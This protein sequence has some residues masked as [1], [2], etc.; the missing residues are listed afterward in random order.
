MIKSMIGKFTLLD[1]GRLAIRL[2]DISR[3]FEHDQNCSIILKTGGY[4][5]V[6]EDY[7]TVVE[8][9]SSYFDENEDEEYY[10]Y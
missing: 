2:K 9:W 3:V 6:Q 1:G 4:Y 10:K 7:N 5:S 8:V